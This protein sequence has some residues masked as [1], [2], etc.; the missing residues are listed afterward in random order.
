VQAVE[1]GTVQSGSG[2]AAVI[3]NDFSVALDKPVAVIGAGGTSTFQVSTSAVA[4]TP[5]TVTFSATRLPAGVTAAFEPESVTAG[6]SSTLRLSGA[7][8]LPA[9]QTIVR[10]TAASPSTSHRLTALVRA[11]AAPSVRITWPTR[12][13]NLT[14]MAPI[15]AIAAASQGTSLASLELQVDGAKVDLIPDPNSP[16]VLAW[17]TRGV[18][19]G[20]HD[21]TVR[22][23]DSIGTQG[24]SA[25]VLVWVD[26]KGVCGCSS[27]GGSWEALGLLGLLA[28]I[29][30]SAGRR[31]V[32]PR[33]R[34]G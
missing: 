18:G 12:L 19:D 20:P 33:A 9:G 21:L 27:D 23:T 26:N 28:A 5:E 2:N 13:Q 15:V 32:G 17:D 29:R 30:S 24:N 14:G 3:A 31:G 4:G 1:G 8:R 6:G 10:V 7:P 34:E 25:A 22:A 16:V 11:V